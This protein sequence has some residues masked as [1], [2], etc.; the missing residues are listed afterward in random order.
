MR[1]RAIFNG[2]RIDRDDGGT[3]VEVALAVDG[4]EITGY[5]KGGTADDAVPV[6]SAQA[7]LH[8]LRK[9]AGPALELDLVWVQVGS[10]PL[11]DHPP[12]AQAL[13]QCRK[14]DDDEL[15]VGA[16]LVRGDDAVAVVRAVLDALNRPL[17]RLAP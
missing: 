12:M 14:G 13:V 16:A 10:G 17:E 8:A 6:I 7:A 2:L 4:Q 5:A 15:F 11:G 3:G 9:I 1:S